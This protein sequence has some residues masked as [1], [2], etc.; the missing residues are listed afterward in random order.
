MMLWSPSDGLALD[1]G[2]FWSVD[3]FFLV[4]VVD[5]D[6]TVSDLVSFNGLFK[7]LC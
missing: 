4:Y 1:D 2:Y 5:G 6:Q 7:R 3:V